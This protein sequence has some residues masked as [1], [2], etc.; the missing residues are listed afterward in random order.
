MVETFRRGFAGGRQRANPPTPQPAQVQPLVLAPHGV[1]QGGAI[2]TDGII[3]Q[4][5][6]LVGER[7]RDAALVHRQQ[8]Q[9]GVG[10]AGEVSQPPQTHF[11]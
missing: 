5:K 11:E 10:Q 8:P 6:P 9:V 2:G 4:A 7:L 1:G 3:V